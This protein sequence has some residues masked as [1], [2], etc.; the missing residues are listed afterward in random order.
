MPHPAE[1]A[2]AAPDEA[3]YVLVYELVPA[4][5][6]MTPLVDKLAFKTMIDVGLEVSFS[7]RM[8]LRTRI[9]AP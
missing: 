4:S 7:K 9:D 2:A 6:G 3:W 8:L 1:L 5:P